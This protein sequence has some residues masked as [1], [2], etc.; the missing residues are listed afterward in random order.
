ERRDVLAR[1][2]RELRPAVLAALGCGVLMEEP[3]TPAEHGARHAGVDPRGGEDHLADPELPTLVV[4]EIVRTELG[5]AQKTWP[6]D[7][8]GLVPDAHE[9]AQGEPREV[10]PRQKAL[11]GQIAIGVEVGLDRLLAAVEQQVPL[12]LRLG[13]TALRLLL[14]APCPGAVA[15]T[16]GLVALPERGAIEL[17]PA[18]EGAVE[19]LGR[20]GEH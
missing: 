12:A 17:A 11:A 9:R 4:E 18:F 5:D 15:R 2:A 7:G 3:A 19:G 6:V 10:V 8:V 20:L 16:M 13:A 1:V 14:L